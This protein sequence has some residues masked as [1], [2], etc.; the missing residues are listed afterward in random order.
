MRKGGMN[1]EQKMEHRNILE[2]IVNE[3]IAIDCRGTVIFC[4]HTLCHMVKKQQD[5]II[6]RLM[7]IL[8]RT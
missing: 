7:Q 4:N 5:E 2:S 1:M 3:I 8:F 6:G